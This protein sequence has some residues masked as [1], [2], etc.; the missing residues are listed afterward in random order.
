MSSN[1]PLRIPCQSCL[2]ELQES[3][4]ELKQRATQA[5]ESVA[6]LDYE[7]AKAEAS[8]VMQDSNALHKEVGESEAR[9]LDRDTRSGLQSAMGGLEEMQELAEAL[10]SELK[11]IKPKAPKASNERR[12]GANKLGKRQEKLE[13]VVKALEKQIKE[14]DQELPGLEKALEPNMSEAKESMREASE[15]LRKVKPGEAS[16]HQ[17]R[18][19]DQLGAMKKTIDKRIQDASGRGQKGVG[20]HRK[21]QRVDIPK[22]ERGSP[23]ALRDALLKAMKELEGKTIL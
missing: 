1:Y 7:R 12:R 5:R 3:F 16:G 10:L 21:D 11:T 2:H 4:D 6:S 15:E 17:R 20:I 14:V 13:D 19:L 18:A 8:R 23:K 9:A 22:E